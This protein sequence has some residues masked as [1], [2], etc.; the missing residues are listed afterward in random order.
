MGKRTR[1]Y[2]SWHL[3]KL[4]DPEIVAAYLNAAMRDSPEAFQKALRNVAQA[5]QIA[6]MAKDAD[7]QKCGS[8]P[9]TNLKQ[10]KC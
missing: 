8:T 4:T 3:Q 5:R 7:I 9:K 1:D 6:S 10:T 2:H